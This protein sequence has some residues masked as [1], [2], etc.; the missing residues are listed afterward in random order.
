MF[1]KL[2][3]LEER[4]CSKFFLSLSIVIGV[5]QAGPPKYLACSFTALESSFQIEIGKGRGV[6]MSLSSFRTALIDF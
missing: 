4:V 6:K 5:E 2:G 3:K 1:V